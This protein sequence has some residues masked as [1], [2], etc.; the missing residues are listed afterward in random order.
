MGAKKKRLK[1][2][3]GAYVPRVRQE[4]L[5]TMPSSDREREKEYAKDGRRVSGDVPGYNG[6]TADNSLAED[7]IEDGKLAPWVAS[8]KGGVGSELICAIVVEIAQREFSHEVPA[9]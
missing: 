3:L 4:L 6:M 1:E 9:I 8:R 7:V 5:P 2:I